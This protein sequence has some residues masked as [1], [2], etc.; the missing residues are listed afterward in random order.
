MEGYQIRAAM[1]A[2]NISVTSIAKKLGIAVPNI[3]QVIH[4][5]KKT[6]RIRKAIADAVGIPISELWPESESVKSANE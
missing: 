1:L 3:S 5:D 2:K 6:P 4:G